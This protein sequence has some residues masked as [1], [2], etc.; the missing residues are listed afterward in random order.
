MLNEK[1]TR[2]ENEM[3]EKLQVALI[4]GCGIIAVITC[5]IAGS[6]LL[7]NTL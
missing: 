2:K 7:L 6:W 4:I 1:K 3:I 5:A